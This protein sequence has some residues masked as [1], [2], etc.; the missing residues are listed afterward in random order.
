MRAM[1]A[2]EN[3]ELEILRISVQTVLFFH[4]FSRRLHFYDRQGQIK[5]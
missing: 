2:S 4:L 5:R 1:A 3:V